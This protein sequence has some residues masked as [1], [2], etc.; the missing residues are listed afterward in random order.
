MNY[1][2]LPKLDMP[3]SLTTPLLNGTL[4]NH[5]KHILISL[6]FADKD[7]GNKIYFMA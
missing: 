2:K 1:W 6:R 4:S 7:V 3:H 5:K